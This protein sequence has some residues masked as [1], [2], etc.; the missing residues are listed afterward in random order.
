MMMLMMTMTIR[1]SI[2]CYYYYYS[3]LRRRPADHSFLQLQILNRSPPVSFDTH[4]KKIGFQRNLRDPTFRSRTRRSLANQ[5]AS[6]RRLPY[7]QLLGI[8]NVSQ[9]VLFDTSPNKIGFRRTLRDPHIRRRTRRS[10]TYQIASRRR[11]QCAH[12]LCYQMCRKT[13]HLRCLRDTHLYRH[14]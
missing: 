10:R 2:Y 3:R 4:P 9:D 6:R 12:L 8:N 7:T 1:W 14:D 11:L 13:C 5:I